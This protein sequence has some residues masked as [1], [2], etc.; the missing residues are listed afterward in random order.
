M[1]SVQSSCFH[2]VGDRIVDRNFRRSGEGKRVT[3]AFFGE[4]DDKNVG[5]KPR[6]RY[7]HAPI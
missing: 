6:K 4:I 2:H 1:G 5:S 3:L 7:S